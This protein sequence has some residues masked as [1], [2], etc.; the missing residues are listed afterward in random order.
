MSSLYIELVKQFVLDA[1]IEG[2][3]LEDVT[4]LTGMHAKVAYWIAEADV[5]I[6]RKH[7]DWGFLYDNFQEQCIANIDTYS[8]LIGGV[9]AWD[10]EGSGLAISVEGVAKEIPR[11]DYGEFQHLK[12]FNPMVSEPECYAIGPD[13]KIRLHPTPDKPD[14]ILSIGYWKAPA[15]MRL[16][17]D[18][19]PIPVHYDRL[20]VTKAKQMWAEHDE[21]MIPLNKGVQDLAEMTQQLEAEFLPGHKS[22]G[23]GRPM[24][25]DSVM[26]VE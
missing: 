21:V 8:P 12:M 3:V 16:S 1:G 5:E 9:R 19:S 18:V 13:K 10:I 7:I 23:M 6:Q 4:I 25:G 15:R 26:V 11:I 2:T 14:Y 24:R 17:S 22:R 20:I